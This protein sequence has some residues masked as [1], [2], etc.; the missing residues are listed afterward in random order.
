MTDQFQTTLPP[1]DGGPEVT[2]E[3]EVQYSFLEYAMA[4]IVGRA[5]PDV[6]DGLKPVQRRILYAALEAGLR[7]D[8]QHRK[9]AALIGDVMKKYHP[10]GDTAI[11]D[12]L[13]RMAQDFSTRYPLI[14]G[15]GNFGSIDGDEAAAFRYT[16]SR[17]SQLAMQ[18][19][20]DI[21][22]DTVDFADNFDG[23]EQEPTVLPARFPN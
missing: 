16:E 3:E 21:D 13:V 19:L 8:R 23:F 5:L 18:L 10:H 15:Q 20:R 17:L 7:P 4:V 1:G 11:Y 9:C 22:E 14:D 6:R 12:A 2:I